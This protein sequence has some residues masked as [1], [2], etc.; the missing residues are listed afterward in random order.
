LLLDALDA[1]APA[2]SDAAGV[3]IGSRAHLVQTEAVV[4]VRYFSAG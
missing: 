3:A 2:K 1:L 4:K